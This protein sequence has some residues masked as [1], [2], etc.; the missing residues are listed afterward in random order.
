MKRTIGEMQLNPI[1]LGCMGM[2]DFYGPSDETLSRQTLEHALEVGV[3]MFD[4]ADTYGVG[5]N[6]QLIASVL[7]EPMQRGMVKVATKFGVVRTPGSYERRID[8]S[9]DYIRSACEAS[10]RRLGVETIDLYYL[11]RWDE[12]CALE[13]TIGAMAELVKAGKVRHIGLCECSAEMLRR[14][15]EIHPIAAVQSEYSLWTR[16]PETNG[17]LAM[18]EQLGVAFVAYSPLGRGF[19]TGEVRSG[20]DFSDTDMRRRLPRFSNE[21]LAR[22]AERLPAFKAL[23]EEKGCTPAQLALAAL[24]AKRP[25]VLTIPGTR[26]PARIDENMQALKV[27]LT[28]EDI[29]RLDELFPENAVLG[30]RYT[31]EGMKGIAA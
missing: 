19:L 30:E 21:N 5:H 13:E 26:R 12:T 1:G 29:A 7:R 27:A 18:C 9:P 6:E 28:A 15:H 22:N 25:F 10:L 20:A 24:L 3:D 11:H 31:P 2:S 8:N 23:A 14:A 16:D 17:V 4:T